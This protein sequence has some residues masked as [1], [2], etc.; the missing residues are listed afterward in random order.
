MSDE[1]NESSKSQ[2]KNAFFLNLIEFYLNSA[3]EVT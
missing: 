3:A 2:T 1:M